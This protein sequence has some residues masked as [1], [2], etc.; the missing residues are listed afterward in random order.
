MPMHP[1]FRVKAMRNH[2]ALLAMVMLAVG[3]GRPDATGPVA[4]A[5]TASGG[6]DSSSAVSAGSNAD[7]AGAAVSAGS[8]LLNPD[9][10]TM[11]FLYYG[12]AGLTPPIDAWV[13]ADPRV[14][15]AP[16]PDK[17]G[18]RAALRA[19]LQAAFVA[20]RGTGRL[21]LSMQANL[22]EYDPGYGEFTVRALAPSSVVEYQ[23]FGQK[24]A[25][26]FANSRT[27][28]IW[29]VPAADAQAVRDRIGHANVD[30]DVLLGIVG[31]QPGPGGGTITTQVLEY[32]LREA[33]GGT[34]I[35]RVQV[36]K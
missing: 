4:V 8:E 31:V 12:L 36:G 20:V 2:C 32:E 35:G 16:A 17:A 5:G 25:V 14:L 1:G 30:M 11:V 29:K 19:E 26:K 13:E 28:Q 22:S 6:S 15:Y 9:D 27:A 23:A 34:T 18:K 10:A 24:V 33:R 7:N 3:C 21:R